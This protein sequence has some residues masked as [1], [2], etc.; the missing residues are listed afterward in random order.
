MT[1]EPTLKPE[2]RARLAYRADVDGMRAVAV[3][4]VLVFHAGL[5]LPGGFVGVDVF[6][7]ISGFLITSIVTRDVEAGTFSYL[8]FWE[9]RAR[10]L[11]PAMF[12]V[13]VAT[14]VLG[15]V[16]LLPHDFKELGQSVCAQAA[17]AANFYF[18]R[19]S[20]YFAGP[21]EIKP[22]LHTWSLAVEVQ[23]YFLM[24]GLLVLSHRL[25]PRRIPIV[26]VTS[27]LTSLA[28]C[29]YS[30]SVYPDA[31]FYL[32]PTR[33][34]EMMLGGV[35]ALPGDFRWLKRGMA[36]IVSLAGLVTVI[37]SIV[38]YKE[39]TPFP[40]RYA[41][42]PCLGTAAMIARNSVHSTVS[43]KLLSWRPVVFVGLISYSL[44]L[45]HWP[46]FAF[47]NYMTPGELP[48]WL[49]ISLIAA[50][51]VM[52]V[53]SWKHVETPFR[54][55]SLLSTR[56][57]VLGAATAALVVLGGIGAVLHVANGVRSRFSD[58]VLQ[59]ADAR[60]DKN[61]QRAL[62][63]DLQGS[64]LEKPPKLLAGPK[65]AEPQLIIVG[66]SHGDAIVPGIVDLCKRQNVPMV[67]F[68][69]S[70]TLPLCFTNSPRDNSEK[71]FYETAMAYIQK[72]PAK[73]VM[74]IARW[75]E[76][77]ERL[78]KSNFL[79]TVEGLKAFGK[80]VWV[81]RQV[82]EPSAD[83]PRFLALSE[84][85]G[86]DETKIRCSKEDYEIGQRKVDLI[87]NAAGND[88]VQ[89]VDV[90]ARFFESSPLAVAQVDGHPLYFDTNHLS[91]KGAAFAAACLEPIIASIASSSR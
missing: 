12:V 70:D 67:A 4:A 77:G 78:D 10:R 86:M 76:Y 51:L 25:W 40:G 91:T 74:L 50:S 5:G 35:V 49:A 60:Q 45:W 62:H 43:S 18:Y 53:L 55:K 32:L 44:Y 1:E 26:L 73:D 90:S 42:L 63:H 11:V 48:L 71:K 54:N 65:G 64:A 52:G 8:G 81:L 3:L 46:L 30:S 29:V 7:V 80:N 2:S 13:V 33:A 61:R 34:W 82:P 56:T 87:L 27:L 37:G 88:R 19:E 23:F 89:I 28:W 14:V 31:A 84:T 72:S 16:I 57:R 38:F 20:G 66:D 47:A 21:S 85:W 75:S 6:F 41:L 69:K 83:V 17:A 58:G 36:E 22:L 39:G 79:A 9:R 24:P 68:T 15:Y 59:L